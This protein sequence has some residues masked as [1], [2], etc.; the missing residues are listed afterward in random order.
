[1]RR[2]DAASACSARAC[3]A[4]NRACARCAAAPRRRGGGCRPAL[5]HQVACAARRRSVR[6][7]PA[8]RFDA[9]ARPSRP[10]ARPRCARRCSCRW[11]VPAREH[12][13]QP[14]Q[15]RAS[16]SS[17]DE[18]RRRSSQARAS[19]PSPKRCAIDLLRL[20]EAVIVVVV[21][22]RG[23]VEPIC[24]RRASPSSASKSSSAAKA[25][26]GLQRAASGA[27]V[28]RG[29]LGAASRRSPRLSSACAL[30]LV[31]DGEARRH[32]GLERK[33]LQQP[34]AE[35]VDGLHLEPAGRLDGDGEQLARPLHLVGASGAPVEQ[36]GELAL[37]ARLVGRHPLGQPR[38]HALRHLRGGG[39]GVGER[40]D[41]LGR[42]AGQQQAQ[43]A[44]GQHVRLAGAGVG[45]DP[46][47]GGGIGGG[48]L[49]ALRLLG[50]TAAIDR[51]EHRRGPSLTP[52]RRLGR[53]LGNAGEM[54][55]VVVAI[56][57][58]GA[59]QR[60]IG[61]RLSIEL[62]DQPLQALLRRACERRNV[63]AL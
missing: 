43:H 45:A 20:D 2:L 33:A 25:T 46:S 48:R 8:Q 61:R 29:R 27:P 30:V 19:G 28:C 11:P 56:V 18:L 58:A 60:A 62:G 15:H 1:M 31:E 54:G 44:H 57:E 42:R 9:A 3:R 22:A 53:P 55:V 24:S 50:R 6:K 14:R 40:Q 39:L 17:S 49:V 16:A 34:L 32:A 23:R 10:R 5:G 21:E 4:T 41:A 52:P 47:R 12:V 38:E 26:A 63:V 35:G 59:A 7:T 37:Q 13:A 36:L 51:L